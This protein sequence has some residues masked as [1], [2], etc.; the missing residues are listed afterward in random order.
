MANQSCRT[1][2]SGERAWVNESRGPHHERHSDKEEHGHRAG[3]R[4]PNGQDL[5]GSESDEDDE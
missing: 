5:N 2:K 4:R 3:K 1:G